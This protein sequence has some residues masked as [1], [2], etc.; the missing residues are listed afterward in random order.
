M[1]PWKRPGVLVDGVKQLLLELLGAD[2][3]LFE[4]GPHLLVVRLRV[5]QVRHHGSQRRRRALRRGPQP[6]RRR[7][8]PSRARSRRQSPARSSTPAAVRG[9]RMSSMIFSEGSNGATSSGPSDR[10]AVWTTSDSGTPGERPMRPQIVTAGVEDH[11]LRNQPDELGTGD[12]DAPRRAL[13]SQAS[14]AACSGVAS[15][16]TRFIDT[17]AQPYSGMYQPTARTALSMP[18]CSTVLPSSSVDRATLL[19]D[20]ERDPVRPPLVGDVEVDVVRHQE[21]AGA[22]HHRAETGARTRRDRSPVRSP[23]A[24]SFFARAS[25]SPLRMSAN[26]RRSG[27]VAAYS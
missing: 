6:I 14:K 13:A 18:G 2:G 23:V 7:A 24:A 22:D 4:L 11:R 8:P 1:R 5:R 9:A 20:V 17:W 12:P 3:H 27:R 15:R 10:I 19:A 26:D 25:Y 16:S 21:L